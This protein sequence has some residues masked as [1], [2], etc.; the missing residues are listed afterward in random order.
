MI[1]SMEDFYSLD[2]L[3]VKKYL[4]NQFN[5]KS[6]FNVYISL[7]DFVYI[8]NK[9]DISKENYSLIYQLLQSIL[10]KIQINKTG[11]NFDLNMLY[12]L[13]HNLNV[14]D[15]VN[16][17]DRD[18]IIHKLIY[19]IINILKT[20]DLDI[21]SLYL[22]FDE[23]KREDILRF[24]N[25]LDPTSNFYKSLNEIYN[26]LDLNNSIKTQTFSGA[27]DPRFPVTEFIGEVG[28]IDG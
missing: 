6:L 5:T 27:I 14:D 11:I 18:R 7:Y 20:D 16:E 26:S 3:E 13:Y 9:K 22:T 24:I 15:K 4:T 21:I 8:T 23:S 17:I 12:E 28:E 1:I 10:S 25:T 19:K 2:E